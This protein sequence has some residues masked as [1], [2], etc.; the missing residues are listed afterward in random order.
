[1]IADLRGQQRDEPSSPAA[2]TSGD[3]K[4]EQTLLLFRV[5]R[6]GQMALPLSKVARLEEF[7]ASSVE[8]SSDRDV[9][10][11]RGEILPLVSLTSYFTGAPTARDPLQ[12][13]VYA[14]GQRSCGLIVEE[15]LDVVQDVVTIS[16][17]A[18]RPGVLGS[19]IIQQR[20]TDLLDVQAVRAA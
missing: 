4:E 3:G 13:I 19:A 20:V 10:Q 11:Y 5:N 17:P 14:D 7:P 6:Q 8:R 12:V 2:T 15:I 18:P 9:V 1:V 16:N